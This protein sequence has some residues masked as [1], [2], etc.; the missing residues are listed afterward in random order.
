MSQKS[1]NSS[2]GNSFQLTGGDGGS[3]EM[4]RLK[5]TIGPDVVDIRRLYSE[6]G[7]FTY[8]P[9]FVATASCSSELTYIDGEE[10]ILLH[11]GY[12]IQQLAENSTF[13]EVAYLLLNGE[14]P[15]AKELADFEDDLKRYSMIHDQLTRLFS[16]FRRDAHPMAIM[17]GVVGALSAFYHDSLDINDPQ[18]RMV[19]SYRLIAKMP[20]IAAMA[21]K[22]SIGQ[23]RSCTRVTR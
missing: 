21:Y 18:H 23:S 13:P 7:C 17:V 6:L 5:G 12:P 22:Y 3:L 20:T 9:G 19:A 14:L 2:N 10:G 16:G 4:P 1:E 8:D 15:S 11:R